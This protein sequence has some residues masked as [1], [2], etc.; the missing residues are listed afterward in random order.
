MLNIYLICYGQHFGELA[1]SAVTPYPAAPDFPLFRG[2][3]KPLY[4][5]L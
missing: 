3:N 4:V 2:Q 1:A 5:Y